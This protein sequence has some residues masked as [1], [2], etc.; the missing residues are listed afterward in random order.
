MILKNTS[1][2]AI[3]SSTISSSLPGKIPYYAFRIVP[4]YQISLLLLTFI[5][6]GKTPIMYDHGQFRGSM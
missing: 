6:A 2:L 5:I 4:I 1:V 3:A